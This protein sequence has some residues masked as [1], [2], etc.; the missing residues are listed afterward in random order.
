MNPNH[1][2]WM[3]PRLRRAAA[4][5]LAELLVTVTLVALLAALFFPLARTVAN[6]GNRAKGIANL[7][8]VGAAVAGYTGDHQGRLPGPAPLGIYPDY[9]APLASTAKALGA[10]LGV[11]LGLPAPSTLKSG[12]TV[13]VPALVCPGFK[14]M[15]KDSLLA[16]NL[17]QNAGLS[18]QPGVEGKIRVFGSIGSDKPPLMLN[19]LVRLGGLS[20]IWL[21]TNLDQQS[22]DR[23]TQ[24][25]GWVANLPPAPVYRTTRLRLFAD[26][27]VE[28]VALDAPLL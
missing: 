7:R 9:N 5:T 28:A 1:G 11:Y 12:E 19:D 3:A 20:K 8:Q 22:P 13:V 16:P 17:V 15:M 18:D 25:S 10:A 14:A 23:L 21:L 6:S 4:L 2:N 24:G 27:H 26:G